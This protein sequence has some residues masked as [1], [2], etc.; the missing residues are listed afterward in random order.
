MRKDLQ[1]LP[2]FCKNYYI[3]SVNRRFLK[4]SDKEL[5]SP[6]TLSETPNIIAGYSQT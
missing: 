4:A 2:L 3:S 5:L 6:T 1:S